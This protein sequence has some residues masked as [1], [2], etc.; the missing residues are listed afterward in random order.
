MKKNTAIV[1][2]AGISGL[3]AAYR[4]QQRG[5][6]VTVLEA[7]KQAGGTLKPFA[8]RD[9]WWTQEP[10]RIQVATTVIWV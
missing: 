1:V 2:V 9:M 3:I 5:F 8:N 4:L 6:D 7:T 10:M